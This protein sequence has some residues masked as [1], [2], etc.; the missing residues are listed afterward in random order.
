MILWADDQF[1][2]NVDQ[3]PLAAYTRVLELTALILPIEY[4]VLT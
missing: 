2:V 1:Y 3:E 4:W